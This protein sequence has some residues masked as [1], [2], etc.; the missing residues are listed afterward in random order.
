VK[1]LTLCG[2]TFTMY[3]GGMVT[4]SASID[5]DDVALFNDERIKLIAFLSEEVTA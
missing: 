3:E 5:M 4:V 2:I 1:N